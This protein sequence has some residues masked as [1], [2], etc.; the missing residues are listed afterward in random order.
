MAANIWHMYTEGALV[1]DWLKVA[2]GEAAFL[3]LTVLALN[4]LARLVAWLYRRKTRG[5]ERFV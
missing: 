1:T 3:L 2:S 4:M 5:A